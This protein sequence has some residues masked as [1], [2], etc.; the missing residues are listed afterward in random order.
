M[1]LS[2]RRIC[3]LLDLTY[4][5][6][7]I[8]LT[9]IRVFALLLILTIIPLNTSYLPI[10]MYLTFCVLYDFA[11]VHT[12]CN[13]SWNSILDYI[14]SFVLYVPEFCVYLWLCTCVN[15]QKRLMTR[16]IN[17][18]F[19]FS[20]HS[21]SARSVSFLPEFTPLHYNNQPICTWRFV[22]FMSSHARTCAARLRVLAALYHD[23]IF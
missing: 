17:R 5:V 8:Q 22:Y 10:C 3:S 11:H 16:H 21:L 15:L 20:L 9:S 1:S 7:H 4:V 19:S 13:D 23:P 14:F 18:R 6:T 2:V 12:H